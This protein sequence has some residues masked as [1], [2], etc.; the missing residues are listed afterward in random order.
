M[1]P[2]YRRSRQ[3]RHILSIAAAI[4]TLI[5][6]TPIV[7]LGQGGPDEE[8][9]PKPVLGQGEPNPKPQENADTVDIQILSTNDFHGRLNP[10]TVS[11]AQAGGAAW[12]SAYLKRAEATTLKATLILDGGDMV[13]AT[14]LESQ[15]FQD[16]PNI[17]VANAIGYDD[18][19]YGNHEFD[20]GKQ[21]L[22]KQIHWAKY[23][24]W[25]ANVIDQSTDKPFLHPAPYEIFRLNGIEVG[26][27][28][29]TTG[30]TPTIVNPKGIEDLQ[31]AS[32]VATA[33]A[34]VAALKRQNVKTIVLV[35]H[36]GTDRCLPVPAPKCN[37]NTLTTDPASIAK[38]EAAK[39][40]REVDDQVDVIIAGHTHQG[41]NTVI[42][43]KRVV[44]AY[45]YGTAYADVD[46][47]VSRATK[48]EVSSTADIITTW[49]FLP[50][51]H[52]PAIAPDKVVQRIVDEANAKVASS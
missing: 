13:G 48:D 1:L 16:R 33:N 6:S 26:V 4:T 32:T 50:G 30:A 10:Q 52:T 14:P 28:N 27:I 35:G 15:A 39:L 29:L 7:M 46:L 37:G 34:A 21:R 45:S 3:H 23:P 47:K 43:G 36:L 20:A 11:K 25:S 41:V 31:F 24:Y 38:N 49:H 18:V 17:D 8:R 2:N 51:T 42:D 9:P 44:E 22:A 12:P 40:A 5:G 19:A